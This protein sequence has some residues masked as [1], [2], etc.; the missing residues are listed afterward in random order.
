MIQ[1]KASWCKDLPARNLILNALDMIKVRAKAIGWTAF[2]NESTLA[3][4]WIGFCS[5]AVH[6]ESQHH[7]NATAMSLQHNRVDGI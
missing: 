4:V 5:S 2:T 6:A 1:V 3:W 7:H